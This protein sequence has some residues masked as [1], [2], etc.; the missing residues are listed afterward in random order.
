MKTILDEVVESVIS[1]NSEKV[2]E[3]CKKALDIGIDP[4]KVME[5]GITKGL[6][7]IGDKYE[8]GELFI[9]HLIAAS[10]AVKKALTEVI[11]PKILESKEGR[12]SAGKVVIGTVSGDIHDIGKNIVAAML[13]VEGF[14]VHDL[15]KDVPC[16]RF[17]QKALEVEA[18]IIAMS[19]LLSAT[20]SEQRRI[21]EALVAEGIRD[22]LKVMVGG[23]VVTEEWSRQIGADGYGENAVE[24]V[25]VAKRLLGRE[26]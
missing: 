15:G 4:I 13:F 19:A 10:E 25:R 5:N 14:E 22:K 21:V 18:D 1:F 26:G 9:M 11:E 6:R 12:R 16:E 23:A 8:R 17:L 3:N 7:I 2:V 24:A 20:M